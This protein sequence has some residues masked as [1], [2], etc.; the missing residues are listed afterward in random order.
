ME[1]HHSSRREARQ[2]Q[3]RIAAERLMSVSARRF[4]LCSHIVEA[5]TFAGSRP[6]MLPDMVRTGFRHT[7]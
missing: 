1:G 6:Y 4:G 3:L 7:I 5:M 2:H